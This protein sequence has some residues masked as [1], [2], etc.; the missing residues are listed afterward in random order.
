MKEAEVKKEENKPEE[1]VYTL[2]EVR[3]ILALKSREGHTEEIKTL[4]GK[5][6]AANLSGVKESD[7]AALVKEAE[8]L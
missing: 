6:G 5:Y 8:E 2:V 3:Q 1:K 7:Y 4:L